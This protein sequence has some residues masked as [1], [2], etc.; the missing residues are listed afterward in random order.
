MYWIN[1]V[2][3]L[4]NPLQIEGQTSLTAH[5]REYKSVLFQSI[6]KLE[7]RIRTAARVSVALKHPDCAVE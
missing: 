7:T 1:F 2:W 3:Q 4:A 6:C 5:C